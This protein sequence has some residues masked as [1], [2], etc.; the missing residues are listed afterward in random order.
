[1]S[2]QSIL[3]HEIQDII[4]PAPQWPRH[5]RIM[6]WSN[7]LNYWQRV[8]LAAFVWINGLNPEV[9]YNWFTIR[10]VMLR[11]SPEQRHLSQLFNYYFENSTK[12]RLWSWNVCM[13]SYQWLDGRVRRNNR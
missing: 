5:I 6:F 11:G 13:A 8:C 7:R 10:N 2:P 4:G 3:W 1:M 9:I 12:Y